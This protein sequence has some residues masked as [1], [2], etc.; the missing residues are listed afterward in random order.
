MK[1]LL[2]RVRAAAEAPARAKKLDLRLELGDGID[3]VAVDGGKLIQI[4]LHLVTNAI[5]F[6]ERGEIV[7]RASVGEGILSSGWRGPVLEVAVRDSGQGISPELH[8]VIFEEFRQVDSGP[9][10][11]DGI[12]LGLAVCRGL[13][14]LLRGDLCVEST[15]GAGST[16]S[17]RLPASPVPRDLEDEAAGLE[18]ASLGN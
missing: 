15:V 16:F 5:K 8:E 10:R 4:L 7:I 17:V 1:A 18:V 9:N 12:G 6:T 11:R 2:E 13:V 3:G 14:K